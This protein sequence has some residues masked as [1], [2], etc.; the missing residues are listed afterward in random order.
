MKS[1]AAIQIRALGKQ[2]VHSRSATGRQTLR[3]ALTAMGSAIAMRL[4]RARKSDSPMCPGMA[5]GTSPVLRW[6][7]RDVSVTIAKGDVVG[8]I[9]ANGAGK[10]TLLKILSRIT[11]PTTGDVT[12]HGR[13]GS[14]LEVGTGFHPELSGRENIYLYGAILGMRRREVSA[15]FKQIAEYAGVTDHLELPVKRYSSG[16]YVRLAF[17]VAAFLDTDILFVDEVL[18][19]GDV[20]F[21]RRCLGTV[22]ELANSGRTVVFVSHNMSI[23]QS[24]CD[25]VLV[26]DGGRLVFDG[27]TPAGV[28]HYM[29]LQSVQ[30]MQPLATRTRAI[31]PKGMMFTRL[32]ISDAEGRAQSQLMTGQDVQIRLG[33]RMD[34]DI[35]GVDIGMTIY[36]ELGVA[37]SHLSTRHGRDLTADSRRLG[38]TCSERVCTIKRLPLL[39]GRY[40]IN[41]VAQCGPENLD[42][43]EDAA[44]F[45]VIGGDYF[46][47]GRLPDRGLIVID[48]QW[49][50]STASM[51]AVHAA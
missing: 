50:A 29:R 26:I 5:E 4:G 32:Q 1:S 48:H 46:G 6:A 24:L 42:H 8:L 31:A 16:M 14:L 35:G 20:A 13:A 7:L 41:I 37:V 33:F 25:R 39:P 49:Q 23:I 9:G 38:E 47:T 21:Q 22:K 51:D 12:L 17:A 44:Q 11:P 34:R 10:S 2:Y 27:P 36:D 40:R 19:V 30:S 15:K 45:D 3:E 18:A 43:I 28:R